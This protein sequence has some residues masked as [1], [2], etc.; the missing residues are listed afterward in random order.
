MC[1]TTKKSDSND[2]EVIAFEEYV[3]SMKV[4]ILRV[5]GRAREMAQWLRAWLLFQRP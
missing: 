5:W 2:E 4:N 3:K 1:K